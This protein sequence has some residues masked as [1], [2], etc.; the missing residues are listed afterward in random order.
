MS[1]VKKYVKRK[2]WRTI[3]KVDLSISYPGAYQFA[4]IDPTTYK[5][6]KTFGS[7]RELEH[8]TNRKNLQPLLHKYV[9]NILGKSGSPLFCGWILVPIT[10]KDLKAKTLDDFQ[11]IIQKKAIDKIIMMQLQRIRDNLDVF[12][13]K[14]KEKIFKFLSNVE[15]PNPNAINFKINL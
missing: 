5:F 9:R 4:A 10:D 2:N 8:A 7:I 1:E 11:Q 12:T 3:S 14:D 15:D 6:V 13:Y